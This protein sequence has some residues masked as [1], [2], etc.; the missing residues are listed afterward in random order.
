MLE[1]VQ[2][3]PRG[4]LV[5]TPCDSLLMQVRFAAAVSAWSSHRRATRQESIHRDGTR[6]PA[7]TAHSL[8]AIKV[9]LAARRN[10]AATSSRVQEAP[11]APTSRRVDDQRCSQRAEAGP[12]VPCIHAGSTVKAL[13]YRDWDLLD[14]RKKTLEAP[15]IVSA[16]S[17]AL[18]HAVLP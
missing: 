2:V 17:A 12:V 9:Q 10:E 5:L 14:V 13:R 4:V 16:R 11:Q 15:K 1:I 3:P 7:S 6:G 18:E 8:K